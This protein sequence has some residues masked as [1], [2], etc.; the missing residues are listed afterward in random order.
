MNMMQLT[1]ANPTTVPFPYGY[2]PGLFV[3]SG[4]TFIQLIVTTSPRGYLQ[5]KEQ[6]PLN[7]LTLLP[8][9]GGF[10]PFF[11]LTFGAFYTAES[12]LYLRPFV[13]GWTM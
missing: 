10:W 4:N 9:Y 8:A 6:D 2:L 1:A 13:I 11:I 12:T 5:I 7:V 3:S